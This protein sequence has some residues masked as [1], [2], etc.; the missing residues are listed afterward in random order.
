M[1]I[2]K[3]DTT[4]IEIEVKAFEENIILFFQKNIKNYC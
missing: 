3:N 4:N 1:L 2:V